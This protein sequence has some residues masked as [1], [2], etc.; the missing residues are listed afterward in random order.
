MIQVW[1]QSWEMDLC[2]MLNRR[3]IR[4]AY[5]CEVIPKVTYAPE[6]ETKF[7]HSI[8]ACA[9]YVFVNCAF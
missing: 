1:E 2:G 8:K 9:P 6:E 4:A 5:V 7:I 3:Y